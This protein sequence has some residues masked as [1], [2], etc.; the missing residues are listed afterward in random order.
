MG[1]LRWLLG[2]ALGVL[3]FFLLPAER[4]QVFVQYV[5][6]Y[7]P[8][9]LFEWGLLCRW[10]LPRGIHWP[11]RLRVGWVAGGI[12]LSFLT[13]MTSPQMIESGRFCVGRCL[14]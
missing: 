9:R 7:V 13:D 11:G 3:V 1:S 4:D 14:C 10:L 2:L 5:V 12:L 8:V 6:V